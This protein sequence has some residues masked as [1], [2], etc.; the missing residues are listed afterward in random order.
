M[1]ITNKK[2]ENYTFMQSRLKETDEE[3]KRKRAARNRNKKEKRKK[4]D[5][6]WA[7]ARQMKTDEYLHKKIFINGSGNNCKKEN[8]YV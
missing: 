1:D 5:P 2:K 4:R 6:A 3:K 7:A 8:C